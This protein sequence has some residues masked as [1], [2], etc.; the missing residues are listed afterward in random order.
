MDI[1]K[2]PRI[3]NSTNGL[4]KRDKAVLFIFNATSCQGDVAAMENDIEIADIRKL[5]W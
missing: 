4:M 2:S 5:P 1:P 3:I